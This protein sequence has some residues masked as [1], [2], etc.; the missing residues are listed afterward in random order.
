MKS[1]FAIV[2][3][4]NVIPVYSCRISSGEHEELKIYYNFVVIPCSYQKRENK[5][6]KNP[7]LIR[8]VLSC[9]QPILLHGMYSTHNGDLEEFRGQNYEETED[10]IQKRNGYIF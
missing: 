9:N 6:R 5:I 8:K 7:E 3:M 10:E 4:H 2:T 1:K